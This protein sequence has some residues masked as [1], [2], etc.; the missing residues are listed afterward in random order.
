MDIKFKSPKVDTCH[1]CDV[2]KAKIDLETINTNEMRILKEEQ[3]IHH[4]EAQLAYDCK[5]RDKLL[6][7]TDSSIKTYT[8][9]L[10]QCLPTP[11]LHCGVSFYKRQLWTYN[12]TVHDCATDVPFCYMWYESL[13][14]RGGNDIASCLFKHIDSIDQTSL[15]KSIIFY[16]DSCGGQN[17]NSYVSTMF[18]V[19]VENSNNIH[20]IDHKFL[21]PGHTHMECDT[22]HAVI[23]RKKKKNNAKIHHPR[24][25]FQF[26][27]SVRS[28]KSF[29]VIEM[30][31]SCFF[32]FSLLTKSKFT[33]RNVNENSEKFIWKN[34]KWLRYKKNNFGII[35]Y[36][37]ILDESKPFKRL[38]IHRRGVNTVKFLDL[39]LAYDKLIEISKE[40]KRIY[41]IYCH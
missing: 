31:H 20:T 6:A 15:T 8:F 26:I 11:Y 1:T 24:D 34:V 28:K 32:A 14:N 18:S 13:G 17:K 16:S 5:Q 3:L 23:E 38:N 22:D 29:Q 36:K 10:Q 30:D 39:P 27:R 33:W 7:K 4:M 2:F 40:K 37:N 12:L 9:D 41:L 35:E 21:V 19:F 25:W